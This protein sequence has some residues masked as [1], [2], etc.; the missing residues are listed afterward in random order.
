M[1]RDDRL[2]IPAELPAEFKEW[3]LRYLDQERSLGSLGRLQAGGA[4]TYTETNVTPDR[5]FDADTVTVAKLADIVGTLIS[6][7][8]AKGIVG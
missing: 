7:L 2:D 3:L 1:S 6:D 4:N 5:S 8:R